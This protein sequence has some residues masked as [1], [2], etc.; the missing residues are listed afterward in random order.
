MREAWQKK[1][2]ILKVALKLNKKIASLVESYILIGIYMK[3]L[4]FILQRY[5]KKLRFQSFSKCFYELGIA[6]FCFH[7]P[8]EFIPQFLG[9]L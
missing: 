9:I 5:K 1:K 3:I 4:Y 2:L 8:N 6:F 7:I